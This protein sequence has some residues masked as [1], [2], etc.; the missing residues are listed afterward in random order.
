M[1]IY[2]ELGFSSTVSCVAFHPHDHLIAFASLSE[3]NPVLIYKYD[4]QGSLFI[5]Y[6][7]PSY[8]PISI[9]R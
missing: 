3:D 9:I 7:L 8:A 6:P 4:H 1:V 5:A 2:S